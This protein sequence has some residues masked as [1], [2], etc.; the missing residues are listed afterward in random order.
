MSLDAL[1]RRGF[2]L[3]VDKPVGP[4]SHDVVAWARRA[5]GTKA[6]GHA[7]TLDPAASGVLV[8]AVGEAT[9]LVPYLTLDDKEY[10]AK[11]LLGAET[12]TLDAEGQVIEE[13]VVPPLTI[14]RVRACAASFIG[15]SKQ[16]APAYSAIKKDGVALHERARR[17]EH[18]EAPERDVE[19]HAID[20]QRIDGATL[21]IHLHVGKGYYVRSFARDL[22]RA[23]GT[24]GHLTGL[25][26][27][28]SGA[29][30]LARTIDGALLGRAAHK[31]ESAREALG[32]E[33]ERLASAL[34]DAVPTLPRIQLTE[35]LVRDARHGKP[36]RHPELGEV[37]EGAT[38]AL[39]AQ[40]RLIAIARREGEIVRV[41]R[42]FAPDHDEVS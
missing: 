23:L 42:G 7:G 8:L 41:V 35:E 38:C 16:R 21:D 39:V 33:I 4:T 13:A 25:R 30:S 37:P 26:R 20:V 40:R 11:L 19:A 27:T 34:V 2:V 14:E 12:D 28:R 31:E 3:A 5:I 6:V 24:R 36:I 32:D 29:F 17:G 9:K 18:V 1:A 15:A 10:E 22:A